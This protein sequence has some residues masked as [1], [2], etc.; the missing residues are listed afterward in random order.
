M[1]TRVAFYARS[2]NNAHDVSCDSQ[3]REF[4]RLA[5]ERGEVEVA[6][7]VD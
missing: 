3:L 2:S 5:A 7:W 1:F 6:R 4:E